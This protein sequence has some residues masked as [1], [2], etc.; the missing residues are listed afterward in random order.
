MTLLVLLACGC[1]SAPA[2]RTASSPAPSGATPYGAPPAAAHAVEVA[3]DDR[4]AREILASLSRPR[5][6]SSDPKVLQDLPAVRLAIADSNRTPDVF[7]R[8]FAAAFDETVRTSVFNLRPVRQEKERWQILLEA[9]RARQTELVRVASRRAAALLPGDRPVAVRLQVYF[10]FGIA[11]L[12]DHLVASAQNG[13]EAMIVDLARALGES[14]ADPFESQFQRLARLVAGEAFRQA[15]AAYREG[16]VVWKRPDPSL[17]Q[18]D[19]LLRAVAEAGPVALFSVD[20]NFFPLSVWLKEPM[21][22]LVGELNRTAEKLGEAKEN[23]EARMDLT[24]E[25]RRGNF[26]GRV[27]GP[28]GAFLCDAI[29]QAEGLNGLRAALE[30]GPRA[31]FEAYDRAAQKDHGLVPLSHVIREKLGRR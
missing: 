12:A 27:A 30:K 19:I 11:G 2:V 14:Q 8:D 20:E 29:V 3:V 17:A 4:A 1:T 31:F 22:R 24:S 15:W 28:A 7:E 23:L 16:S 25:I 13:R 18:L 26:M 10:S 9:I 21:N 6:E 5:F